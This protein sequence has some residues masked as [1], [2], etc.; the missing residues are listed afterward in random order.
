MLEVAIDQ[1]S[2]LRVLE[3]LQHDYPLPVGCRLDERYLERVR[4][5]ELELFTVGLLASS[6]AVASVTGAAADLGGFPVDRAYFELLERLSMLLARAGVERLELRDPAGK[7]RGSRAPSQVFVPDR[8]P[9]QVRASLSNGVALHRTWAD[10]CAAA[11]CEL[12]ERDRVL[13]SFEGEVAPVR[14]RDHDPALERA[15]AEHYAV[16][17]YGF[18]PPAVPLC[19]HAA[20]LFLFPRAPHDPIAYGFAAA[21]SGEAA[22]ESATREALQRLAFLYG[23][24][25]PMRAPTPAPTADYHQEHYLYPPEHERLREWLTAR[26]PVSPAGSV[27]F[28]DGD[29]VRFADLTPGS[30]RERVAVAR[31]S[32]RDARIL[33]FGLS[34][35]DVS[36]HTPPHP[37]A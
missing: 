12:V 31:A 30:L 32:S 15:L 25:I 4:I 14:L 5:G 33:R 1:S 23:E 27:S 21:L 34:A 19:Y 36:R 37:I 8:A 11:V 6:D 24:E 22:L 20:G 28:F 29:G 13:R 2:A 16:E 9:D 3:E 35:R 18:D 17:A 26:R 10:A 7:R